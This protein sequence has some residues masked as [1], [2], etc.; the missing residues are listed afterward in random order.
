MNGILGSLLR[1]SLGVGALL[2]LNNL[3]ERG[4]LSITWILILA[5]AAGAIIYSILG[6][7]K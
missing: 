7:S 2:L 1:V 3:F 4:K 5:Y 6:P